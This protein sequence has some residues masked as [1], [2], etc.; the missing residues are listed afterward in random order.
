MEKIVYAL[1]L[2]NTVT[3]QVQLFQTEAHDSVDLQLKKEEFFKVAGLNSSDWITILSNCL[4]VSF[5][6]QKP[7]LPDIPKKERPIESFIHCL[8]YVHDKFTDTDK[9]KTTINKI[10]SI[11]EK[12]YESK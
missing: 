4:T 7:A 10:I 2:R 12:Q 1:Y 11:I 5:P 6:L 9:D 8:R 3:H